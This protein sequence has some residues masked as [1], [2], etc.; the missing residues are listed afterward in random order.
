M[1]APRNLSQ[2]ADV[3]YLTDFSISGSTRITFGGEAGAAAAAE[4]D[5]VR[6]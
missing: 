5:D 3:C 2:R 1:A 4:G 6:S